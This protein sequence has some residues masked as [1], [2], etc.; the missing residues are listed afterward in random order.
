MQKNIL[1]KDIIK[2]METWAPQ[3]TAEEWDNPGLQ[4]GNPKQ[5]I[6]NILI[7]LDINSDI[8]KKIENNNYDLLITHHPLI[9]K[10]IKKIKF[11]QSMGRVI[12]SFIKTDTSFYS[13]HT[14]L[15]IA[16]GGVNDCLIEAFNFDIKQAKIIPETHGKWFHNKTNL[17]IEHLADMQKCTIQGAVNK[18]K[19][20]RI[21]FGCGGGSS[22]INKLIHLNIDTYIT[23]ELNYHDLLTCEMNDITVLMM[24]HK[25]SE[26]FILPKI[27]SKILS[28]YPALDIQIED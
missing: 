10:P 22:L 17:T 24:G 5:E 13:S 25:E 15:D 4:I 16:P 20:S 21:A 23:G 11:N 12:E 14:N 3:D 26:N 28:K 8:L 27:K 19:I 6:E 18:K 2:T 1:L 7:A 9:F